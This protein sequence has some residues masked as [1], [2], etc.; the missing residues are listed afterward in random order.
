MSANFH[1]TFHL[2]SFYSLHITVRFVILC[3]VYVVFIMNLSWC[4]ALSQPTRP[5]S[6][7]Y[8]MT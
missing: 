5:C 7:H 6:I 2:F 1:F 4:G 3:F 8:I